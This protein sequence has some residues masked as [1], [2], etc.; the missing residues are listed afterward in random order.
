[1]A[2]TSETL[3]TA[4]RIERTLDAINS[5]AS[6]RREHLGRAGG[7]QQHDTI[8]KRWPR[9]PAETPYDL[10]TITRREARAGQTRSQPASPTARS[11]AGASSAPHASCFSRSAPTSIRSA[12]RTRAHPGYKERCL[13]AS[14]TILTEPFGL[15]WPDAAHR[16]IPNAATRRR[17]RGDP[18]GLR[19]IRAANR[20]SAPLASRIPPAL[21][22]RAIRTQRPSQ[23]FLGPQPPAGDGPVNLVDSARSRPA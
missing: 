8:G 21:H 15:G 9:S 10:D 18:R 6:A 5:S 17:L 3:G 16:V 22:D 20:L 4:F 13:D 12:S 2:T 7:L 23:P 11:T 19:W 1:M 14:E